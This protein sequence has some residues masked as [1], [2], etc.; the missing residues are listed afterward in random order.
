MTHNCQIVWYQCNFCQGG[1][2]CLILKVFTKIRLSRFWTTS[3]LLRGSLESC[4]DVSAKP[5]KIHQIVKQNIRDK[6]LSVKQKTTE[7]CKGKKICIWIFYS[8]FANK[9]CFVIKVAQIKGSACKLP[10]KPRQKV[11]LGC[12]SC[13]VLAENYRLLLLVHV[14]LLLCVSWRNSSLCSKKQLDQ[15]EPL[16]IFEVNSISPRT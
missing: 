7:I 2:K 4:H 14:N 10:W 15:N 11:K 9:F 6:I 16:G 13:K 5:R 12:S 3:F 8:W 1:Q